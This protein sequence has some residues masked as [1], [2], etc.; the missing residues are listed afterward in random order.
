MIRD[1]AH[2]LA[3]A[4]TFYSAAI[5]GH[6]WHAALEGFAAATGSE[7]GELVCFGQNATVPVNVLT[8]IDPA[9]EKAFVEAGGGDP[10]INP[11]VRAGTAAPPLQSCAEADFI[12]PEEYRRDPHYQEFAIPW[13]IPFVCVTTLEKTDDLL[14]GL[15][16]ARTQRQ[17][18][19]TD[20]QRAVFDSLSPH[21]RAAVRMQ[22]ALEGQ[23]E[24]LLGGALEALSIPAFVCDRTGRV[25]AMTPAAE[26]LA[27][28]DRGIGLQ[29]GH[30]HAVSPAD[31]KAL[32]DTV[33]AVL[34]APRTAG[35]RPPQAVVVHDAAGAPSLVLD[36]IA[37]P[38][39]PFQFHFT[40]RVLIV[41]RGER[42]PDAYR[43]N[44]L[45]VAFALT[46]AEADIAIQVSRGRPPELIA[47]A[48]NVSVGT[49]R[50]QIKAIMAKL[51]VSR[52]IE[53]AAKVN[54]F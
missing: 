31:A 12:T 48:R 3:L 50:S 38:T 29:K 30:L 25:R 46:A 47:M 21:V 39:Q 6:G 27:S 24:A 28:A 53:L 8:G 32:K 26:Q 51:G 40:P 37:L 33:A 49:V 13:N 42:G 52:Q 9:F 5:D 11:R 2:W 23:G 20:A 34:H 4:D 17:G 16:V 43:A 44:L 36:V 54:R 22:F 15:A 1:D 45:Q 10:A 35:E 14:V 41:A 19:I 18:H 7:V